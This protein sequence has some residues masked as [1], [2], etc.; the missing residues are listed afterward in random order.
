MPQARK[1][2]S[3]KLWFTLHG[4]VGAQLGLFLSVVMLSGSLATVSHELD[5]LLNPALR[6]AP[7][8]ERV[9]YQQMLE[10]AQ[11]VYPDREARFIEAPRGARFAAEILMD[12][13]GSD[14]FTRTVRRV[15]VDP[16]RGE[17]QGSSGWFNVQR[18]LRNFHMS[19]SL[20]S[21]GIY[22]VGAFGLLLLTSL[23]TALLFYKKW[24]RRFLVLRL[25][26]G[27]RVFWSDC[28]RLGGLWSLW[29]TSVIALTGIWYFIEMAMFDAGVGLADIPGDPPAL[30]AAGLRDGGGQRRRLSLDRLAASVEEAFPGFRI[31]AVRMPSGPSETVDFVGQGDAVLVRPRANRVFVDPYNGEVLAVYRGER[32]P[33]AYRW[34]HTADPLHFGNF[35]GLTSKLIWLFFG[36]VS[37]GLMITGSYLWLRRHQQRA[38]GERHAGA[39]ALDTPPGSVEPS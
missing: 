17:V 2:P 18:T 31:R 13:P 34:V 33:L 30:S 21:F 37:C 35:A 6:V 9:G 22:V 3:N 19:L 7:Q 24:W 14:D 29:F 36:L 5:W 15:Y 39:G 26:R 11:A 12:L 27:W 10:A 23:V 28:H 1:R 38:R 20:P 4:W 16:Y 8:A 32:L 25:D